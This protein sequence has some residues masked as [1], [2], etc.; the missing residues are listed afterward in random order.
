MV[1]SFCSTATSVNVEHV[2]SN[3]HLVLAH[4]YN[5]L[6]VESTQA[7]LC[8]GAWNNLGLIDKDNI[9]VA[10]SLPDVVESDEGIEDE[11]DNFGVV[12]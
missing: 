12:L 6:S 8:L 2:F 10:T 1:S 11:F 7:T 5:W 4:V 9:R 3:G